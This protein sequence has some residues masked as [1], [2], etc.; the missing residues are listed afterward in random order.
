[1]TIRPYKFDLFEETN[2]TELNKK[3]KDTLNTIKDE[4]QLGVITGAIDLDAEWDSYV[5]KYRKNGGDEI[6]AEYMKAPIVS[7][8]RKGKTVY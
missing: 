1:M 8:L 2:L 7:E 6:I 5:A 4:F 3:Y